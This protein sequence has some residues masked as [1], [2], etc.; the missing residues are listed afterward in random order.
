MWACGWKKKRKSQNVILKVLRLVKRP[1][2]AIWYG[3]MLQWWKFMRLVVGPRRYEL[4]G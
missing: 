3:W 1:V 2:C 4:L